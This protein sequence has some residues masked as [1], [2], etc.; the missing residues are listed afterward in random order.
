MANTPVLMQMSLLPAL[1]SGWQ[2]SPYKS[3][4]FS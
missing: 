3:D 1:W 2:S 4:I